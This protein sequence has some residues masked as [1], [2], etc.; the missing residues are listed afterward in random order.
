MYLE[1][2]VR[3]HFINALFRDTTV[4][5]GNG[6]AVSLRSDFVRSNGTDQTTAEFTRCSF[7]DFHADFAGQAVFN[8][9]GR[10]RLTDTHLAG[11]EAPLP[12]STVF[13]FGGSSDCKSGCPAGSYGTC[14]AVDNC[15]SCI[16]GACTPCSRGTYGPEA[17]AV[18]E[19][20]CLPCPSGTFSSAEGAAG[21]DECVAGS[22]VTL[23]DRDPDGIGVS[24]GG[25]M[26]ELCPAGRESTESGSESCRACSA[27]ENS[28]T[29][30]ACALW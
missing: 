15:Y 3:A 24:A 27:G 25:N 20:Q 1:S 29:G 6:G 23:L 26:C 9:I 2:G 16:I 8:S 14:E 5:N 13:D 28:E 17:G 4:A 22:Y 18:K 11:D 21:C 10:L 7:N 30:K 19:A 12:V